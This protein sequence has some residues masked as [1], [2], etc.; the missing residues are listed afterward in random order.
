MSNEILKQENWFQR[1]WKWTLPLV[2]IVILTFTLFFS[3]IAGHLGDFGKAY[4]EPQLYDGALEI[5][6]ENKDVTELLGQLEPVGKMAILEGDIEY[7]D[8]SNHVYL[9]VRVTGTK[10]KANMSVIA[11]RINDSWEYQKISIRIKNPPEIRQS[12]DV[13]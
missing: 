3:L 8:E 13:K 7:T 6:Q 10:G 1:N 4:A 9:S 5:A 12:I 2:V 11:N